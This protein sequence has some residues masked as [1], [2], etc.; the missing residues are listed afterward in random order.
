MM[1]RRQEESRLSSK[2]RVNN[3]ARRTERFTYLPARRIL[4]DGAFIYFYT[5]DEGL[6]ISFIL[7]R[8][9]YNERKRVDFFSLSLPSSFGT[10]FG[11][12][13]EKVSFG[14]LSLWFALMSDM[15]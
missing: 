5:S 6:S 8:V 14:E 7:Y 3:R 15:G 13:R 10:N 4:R 1:T 12:D 11:S 9:T 2:V